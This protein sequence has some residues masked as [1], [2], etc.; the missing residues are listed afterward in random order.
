VGKPAARESAGIEFLR[1]LSLAANLQLQMSALDYGAT[2]A[3]LRAANIIDVPR[4]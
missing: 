4:R 2:I 3:S 1:K